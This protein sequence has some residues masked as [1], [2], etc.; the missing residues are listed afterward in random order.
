MDT[1][2]EPYWAIEN[3]KEYIYIDFQGVSDD[4]SVMN[5]V[6]KALEMGLARKDKSVRALLITRG[7]KTS[8][9]AMRII[10]VLGKKVQPKIKKSAVVGS[11][12]ILSLLL[13]IY[14]AYTGS[15]MRF[16]TDEKKAINYL[17]ID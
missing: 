14:I 5:Q 10:K 7:G 4:S 12:G 15:N 3:N 13:K 1:L 8:P 2:K 16:F 17:T 11:V 9:A 6:L